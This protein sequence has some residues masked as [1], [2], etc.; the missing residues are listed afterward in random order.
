MR[1]ITGASCPASIIPAIS[2][3]CAPSGATSSNRCCVIDRLVHAELAQEILIFARR[4]CKNVRAFPLCQLDG[5]MT[6]S[7]ATGADQNTLAGLQLGG[8]EKVCHTVSAANGTAAAR[9]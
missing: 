3:N 2:A 7:A 1:S 5:V 9:M 8:L 4:R 6:H